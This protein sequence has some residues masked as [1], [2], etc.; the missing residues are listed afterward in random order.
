MKAAGRYNVLVSVVVPVYKVE[1]C[2]ERCLDSLRRQS[3]SDIEVIMVDDSSPDN[4]GAICERYA[5]KDK[6]FVVFHHHENKGLS[7]A[8]NT[9]IIKASGDYLMFV[10]SD[11]WVH[12]DFCKEAYECAEQN[13][14]DL[15][16]FNFVRCKS[17]A[18]KKPS[19][20]FYAFS[21]GQ[22][23]RKEALDYILEDGGNAAWNKIYRKELFDDISY[24]ESFLYE[25]TG[26][27]YKL[28]YKASCFYY[29]EKVLYYHCYHQGSITTLMSEKVL[30]DRARLNTQ[31]YRNLVAWGY[32]SEMLD[33]RIKDFAL[34]YF[35]RKKRDM[36]DP[37]YKYLY[38]TIRSS[39]GI[40]HRFSKMKIVQF[41]VF[42]YC[43]LLF[44]VYYT[45]KGMKI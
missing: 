15:V 11:D 22:K 20:E 7:A 32:N 8:R 23:S 26:A 31:R 37:D 17:D 4:C 1:D 12:D 35:A 5:E 19:K 39:S 10:D 42:K 16:M 34:W 33:Y 18:F 14:A 9:G 38:Q 2:L 6:R 45:L 40:P 21:Q 36:S 44:E 28:V 24:P 13:R 3:L 30:T 43:P 41:L 25:D 27:T 29:L